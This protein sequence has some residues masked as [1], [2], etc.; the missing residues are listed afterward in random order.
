MRFI[1]PVAV[2]LLV[3]AR[4][5][6][7]GKPH[8]EITGNVVKFADGDTLTVLGDHEKALKA[9]EAIHVRL[10]DGREVNRIVKAIVGI[11]ELTEAKK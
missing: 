5:A 11:K 10:A 9:L 4:P 7:A 3:G 2:I 1:W 6:F 8:Y